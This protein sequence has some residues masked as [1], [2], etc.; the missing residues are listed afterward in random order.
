MRAP[1]SRTIIFLLDKN[2]LGVLPS[3]LTSKAREFLERVGSMMSE[4]GE[5]P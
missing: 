2:R 4:R 5:T 3:A 1:S